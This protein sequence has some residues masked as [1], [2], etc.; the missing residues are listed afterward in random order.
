MCAFI[1]DQNHNEIH[2]DD[3]L[4]LLNRRGYRIADYEFNAMLPK[5]ALK[6]DEED[7]CL[8]KR[9]KRAYHGQPELRQTEITAE[10]A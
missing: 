10:V 3:L 4:F 6:L 7:D 1:L 8:V 5:L 9:A 2:R